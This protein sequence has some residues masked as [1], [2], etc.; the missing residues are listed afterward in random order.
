MRSYIAHPCA[1][2]IF[3]SWSRE[4]H[5]RKHQSF[6]EGGESHAEGKSERL[7][8]RGIFL[9]Q[10]AVHAAPENSISPMDCLAHRSLLVLAHDTF[11]EDVGRLSRREALFEAFV[12][13]ALKFF[14]TRH[15]LANR[16][17]SCSAAD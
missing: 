17:S 14:Q 4:S 11:S 3:V 13:S 9:A 1:R 6:A 8:D 5:R 2:R 7:G 16:E 12:L 15:C 10:H